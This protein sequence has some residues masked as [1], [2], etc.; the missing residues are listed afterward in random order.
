[1]D[2]FFSGP[3]WVIS[4]SVT[5]PPNYIYRFICTITIFS[6]DGG[7]RHR[8]RVRDPGVSVRHEAVCQGLQQDVAGGDAGGAGLRVPGDRSAEDSKI[9]MI[10]LYL[11]VSR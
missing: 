10:K 4:E 3:F 5:D 11:P 1:M 9:I 7:L 6:D 8:G 2:F